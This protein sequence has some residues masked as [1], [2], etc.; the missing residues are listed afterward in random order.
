MLAF[1]P[2]L[3]FNLLFSTLLLP[4]ASASRFSACVPQDIP[5]M[6]ID[7]ENSVTKGAR[8]TDPIKAASAEEC[9]S[10]C[11]SKLNGVGDRTC[12]LAVYDTRSSNFVQ[13]CYLF[14]CPET[15]SCPMSPSPGV[16][17]YSFWTEKGKSNA[18]STEEDLLDS[19]KNNGK[20]Q[21][22]PGKKVSPAFQANDSAEPESEEELSEHDSIKSP[23][24]NVHSQSKTD[25]VKHLTKEDK[26]DTPDRITSKLLHLANNID[27]RLEKIEASYKEAKDSKS[28]LSVSPTDE[29]SVVKPTTSSR[30]KDA[31]MFSSHTK[32]T[33]LSEVIKKKPETFEVHYLTPELSTLAPS[34]RTLHQISTAAHRLV[35]NTKPIFNP[36]TIPSKESKVAKKAPSSGTKDTKVL[37]HNSGSSPSRDATVKNMQTG[38]FMITTQVPATSAAHQAKSSLA[39]TRHNPSRTS[40]L[41]AAKSTLK[42]GD[43]PFT[44]K[45]VQ[46]ADRSVSELTSPE[47]DPSAEDTKDSPQNL[48]SLDTVSHD[49]DKSGLVAALVFGVMFLVL[50]IGLVS[51]KVSEAR[52]RHQ[53]TKLDYLINGMYVDT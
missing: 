40:L 3:V 11:C 30:N 22:S 19:S 49:G 8:F 52:R 39:V 37:G 53:Y 27:K 51:H 23:P 24:S 45:E 47:Q 7:V 28:E 31:K 16:F 41:K 2:H 35:P 4:D 15:E 20:V 12:N 50:V 38:H 21:N 17:S 34:V 18:D 10:A 36:S 48:D 32:D 5:N 42:V 29:K 6:T 46:E 25:E 43:H 13:N 1:T 26:A 14:M 44:S 9:V 33:K